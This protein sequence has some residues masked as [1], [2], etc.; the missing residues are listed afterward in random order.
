MYS[1]LNLKQQKLFTVS[2]KISFMV[3]EHTTQ[4]WFQKFHNG[5]NNLEDEKDHGHPSLTDDN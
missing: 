2:T 5:D 3:N 1:K 4:Y